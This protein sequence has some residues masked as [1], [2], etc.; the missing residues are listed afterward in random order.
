[1]N[2]KAISPR[3][4]T[5]VT[6]RNGGLW[7][8]IY[9]N[10]SDA[11]AQHIRWIMAF[12]TAIETGEELDVEAISADDKCE[13]GVWLRDDGRNAHKNCSSFEH[14]VAAHSIFHVEAGRVAQIVNEQRLDDSRGLMALGSDF[15]RAVRALEHH[16]LDLSAEVEQGAGVA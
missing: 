12:K 15:D 9:V 2:L 8:G 10:I 14:C 16:L 5:H 13:L 4:I 3:A 11:F 7:L 1:M 6:L